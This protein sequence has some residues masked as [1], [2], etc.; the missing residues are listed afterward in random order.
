MDKWEAPCPM[1]KENHEEGKLKMQ[2]EQTFVEYIRAS[3]KF[4]QKKHD[5]KDE[6]FCDNL[7]SEA[8]NV[9]LIAEVLGLDNVQEE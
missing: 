1:C 4:K 7:L 2:S 8:G 3:W 5:V 9:S 6:Y